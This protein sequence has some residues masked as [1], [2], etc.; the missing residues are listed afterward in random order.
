MGVRVPR[1][2]RQV[3]LNG[4]SA[5]IEEALHGRPAASTLAAKGDEHALRLLG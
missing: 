2:L 3:T 1:V 5:T 4:A